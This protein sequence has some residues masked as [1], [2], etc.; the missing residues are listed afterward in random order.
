MLIGRPS[1]ACAVAK[2][3]LR[4]RVARRS[5]A[6]RALQRLEGL[7][8]L[9]RLNG[10]WVAGRSGAFHRFKVDAT[11]AGFDGGDSILDLLVLVQLRFLQLGDAQISTDGEA[12]SAGRWRCRLATP[13]L[14]PGPFGAG[15]A[16][17]RHWP[18]PRK[19]RQSSAHTDALSHTRKYQQRCG[20]LCPSCDTP[21]FDLP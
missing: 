18:G 21:P 2:P 14:A 1:Q 13:F 7:K 16:P 3:L 9:E 6:A 19:F 4:L 20:F 11:D 12:T 17:R 10:V 5:V 8:G 15:T